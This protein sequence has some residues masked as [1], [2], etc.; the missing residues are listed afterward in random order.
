[1]TRLTSAEARAIAIAMWG[2]INHTYKTNTV[3]AYY[4]SCE[5]HGGFVVAKNSIPKDQREFVEKHIRAESGTRY[6]DNIKDKTCFMHPYRVRNGRRGHWN[7]SEEVPFYIF[8]E[9]CAYSIA[10]LAG[11]NLKANP[12]ELR[13]AKATFWN[14][15]DETNPV[16]QNRIIVQEK[17]QNGDPDLI[18]SAAGDWHTGIEGVCEVT[19]ADR[20]THLVQ[21]YDKS[22]DEYGQPYLS[23]CTVY[24]LEP[25]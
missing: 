12:I 13:H 16:V 11:I 18:I 15:H 9:D 22:R 10:V 20:V 25:A 24:E 14:W 4:F 3:G 19:T 7:D 23:R 21:D 8:E 1:M 6:I 5:G 2:K 17:R